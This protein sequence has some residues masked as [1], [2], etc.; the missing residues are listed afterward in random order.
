MREDKAQAG[1]SKITT[2]LLAREVPWDPLLVT[3][4]RKT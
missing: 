1:N 3:P 4:L 2:I